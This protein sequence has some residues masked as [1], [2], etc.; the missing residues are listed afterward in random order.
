[1]NW[2]KWPSNKLKIPRKKSSVLHGVVFCMG[3]EFARSAVLY[4]FLCIYTGFYHD[5]HLISSLEFPYLFEVI[6]RYSL[7]KKLFFNQKYW[8]SHRVSWKFSSFKK[9]HESD[10]SCCWHNHSCLLC[11]LFWSP[12]TLRGQLYYQPLAS[13]CTFTVVLHGS[14]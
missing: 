8:P 5:I 9:T 14:H 3:W 11:T 12:W 10:T 2:K 7:L 4:G 13:P 1:M 6:G